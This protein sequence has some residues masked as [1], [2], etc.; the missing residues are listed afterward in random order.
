MDWKR[1][2]G[3][4]TYTLDEIKEKVVPIAQ[5][6]HVEYLYVLPPEK[7]PEKGRYE[8]V[9][10]VYYPGDGFTDADF[11][12]METIY[13]MFPP[14]RCSVYAVRIGK[15]E[16]YGGLPIE[17]RTVLPPS[18]RMHR[19]FRIEALAREQQAQSIL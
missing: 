11:H 14:G 18:R 2:F 4:D 8:S 12:R 19:R 10:I 9:N 13:S 15:R 7:H 5:A 6:S 1:L 3:R 17:L 16:S